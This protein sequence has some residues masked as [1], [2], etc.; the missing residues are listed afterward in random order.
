[1]A[2]SGAPLAQST[3]L[4]FYFKDN[5]LMPREQGDYYADP[6]DCAERVVRMLGLHDACHD[7]S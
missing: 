4:R 7:P 1:M 3:P 6:V 2:R 5:V